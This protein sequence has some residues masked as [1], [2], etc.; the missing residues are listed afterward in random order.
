MAG[1][2]RPASGDTVGLD[3]LLDEAVAA[4]REIVDC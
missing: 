3:S 4:P 1:R 2:S